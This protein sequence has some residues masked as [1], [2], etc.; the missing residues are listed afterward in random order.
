M[1][2]QELIKQVT[3]K[4]ETWLTD[5]YDETTRAEVRRMLD[6]ADKSAPTL[7]ARSC[8]QR[9]PYVAPRRGGYHYTHR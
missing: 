9:L 2:N 3:T 4:A 6:A 7:S 5:A 1:E 8:R